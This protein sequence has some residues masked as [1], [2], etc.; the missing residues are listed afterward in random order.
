M[1]LS[2]YGCGALWIGVQVCA[3]EHASCFPCGEVWVCRYVDDDVCVYAYHDDDDVTMMTCVCV[4]I[5]MMLIC[6]CVC[7]HRMVT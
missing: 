5:M 4:H 2:V 1:G 3:W 6:V 7:M